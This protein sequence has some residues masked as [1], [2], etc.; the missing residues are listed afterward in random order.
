MLNNP[1]DS[2][3]VVIACNPGAI[4]PAEW[5]AHEA[6]SKA[7]FSSTTILEVRELD[8]G[9]AFRLPLESDLL[10]K[11]AAFIANE[12]LCCPFFTFTLIV[13]AELWLQ[14]TGSEAVKALIQADILPILESG[15][16]PTKE[17]LEA[18]YSAATEQGS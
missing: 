6:V 14:M 3:E 5:E 17:S 1:L 9:Y 4:D 10:R 2:S 13:N 8:N 15:D 18:I 12:R 7:I 16:F 11:T